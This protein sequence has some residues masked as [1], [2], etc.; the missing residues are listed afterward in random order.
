MNRPH[1]PYCRRAFA[2]WL[3]LIRMDADAEEEVEVQAFAFWLWLNGPWSF[4]D[5]FFR[6]KSV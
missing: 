2:S 3:H 1:P 5:P 4:R 6:G